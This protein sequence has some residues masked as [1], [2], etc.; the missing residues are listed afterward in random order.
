MKRNELLDRFVS[1]TLATLTVILL[2]MGGCRSESGPEPAPDSRVAEVVRPDPNVP[3]GEN[4]DR[5]EGWVV[6]LDNPDPDVIV[7]KQEDADIFF[8]N[9]TPGWH[10]TTHKSAIFY[11]PASTASGRYVARASVY[12]FDPAGNRIQ[13]VTTVLKLA[14]LLLMATET[15]L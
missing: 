4:L 14:P 1:P 5:P 9:M 10:I 6:R 13:V 7:G 8:V 2:V 3:Q 11:H 15:S 12:F